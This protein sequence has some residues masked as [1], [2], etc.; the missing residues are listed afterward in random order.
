MLISLLASILA[1]G[2]WVPAT[3]AAPSDSAAVAENAK[4]CA[5]LI[6]DGGDLTTNPELRDC[7]V[8]LIQ[9]DCAQFVSSEDP[10][11]LPELAGC[12]VSGAPGLAVL[13]PPDTTTTP[14]QTRAQRVPPTLMQCVN[15]I[16]EIATRNET[17]VVDTASAE[18]GVIAGECVLR[19]IALCTA[20]LGSVSKLG[21][22]V[23]LFS[24]ELSKAARELQSCVQRITQGPVPADGEY[25]L[26]ATH[27]Y[28]A[29]NTIRVHLQYCLKV[30]NSEADL[31]VKLSYPQY[32]NIFWFDASEKKSI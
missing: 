31:I 3:L 7:V 9:G 28:D 21:I 4:N 20:A 22:S 16:V 25:C 2:A 6:P 1:V 26:D 23:G 14:L 17:S 15:T 30:S 18:L 24:P 29:D 5:T 27:E 13:T 8:G 19:Y 10:S 12:V 32:K 11:T